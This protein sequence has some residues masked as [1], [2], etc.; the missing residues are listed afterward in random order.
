MMIL[1]TA[2]FVLRS[3]ATVGRASAVPF[4]WFRG[5]SRRGRRHAPALRESGS[6]CDRFH[7]PRGPTARARDKT[8]RPREAVTEPA[9]RSGRWRSR[10]RSAGAVFLPRLD[11]TLMT[12]CPSVICAR[13]R[14][15]PPDC[16]SG[17]SRRDR[18]D[19]RQ[20]DVSDP[21]SVCRIAV[22]SS[23]AP[24]AP[25]CSAGRLAFPMLIGVR[26]LAEQLSGLRFGRHPEKRR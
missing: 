11:A 6:D 18:D 9:D 4:S 25:P 3:P 16:P 1:R 10:A 2:R 7:D 22:D 24:M 14:T 21:H 20:D 13:E 19:L 12:R 15:C 23:S 17:G 8:S 26:Q 5:V